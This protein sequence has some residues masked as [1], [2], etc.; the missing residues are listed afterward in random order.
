MA[1]F[2]TVFLSSCTVARMGTLENIQDMQKK[3]ATGEG[4]TTATFDYDS[5]R[6][7]DA[8]KYVLLNTNVWAIASIAHTQFSHLKFYDKERAI[9]IMFYYAS[10]R[11]VELAIFFEQQDRMKTKVQFVRNVNKSYLSV[12][13]AQQDSAIKY[14][15]DEANF[16]LKNDGRG[17]MKYTDE[18][19]VKN[20]DEDRKQLYKPGWQQ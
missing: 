5:E 3:L 1:L 17:Y 18:N 7:Y 15:I 20:S 19:S 14:I 4:V 8:V 16:V 12:L 2:L 6:V 10:S 11:D 9:V 13:S